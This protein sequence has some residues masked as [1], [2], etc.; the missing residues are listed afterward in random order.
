MVG[1]HMACS[2]LSYAAFLVAFVA[3]GCFLLQE[4]QVKRRTLGWWFHRLPSLM[5]LDRLNA[6]AITAGFVLL[7]AGLACGLAG[8]RALRG[9]WWVQDPKVYTALGLWA[10]YF[11]LWR[12]RRRQTL[13]GRRVAILSILGFGLLVFTLLQASYLS[14]SSHPYL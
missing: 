3:G 5:V 6:G 4:R 1:L 13:R 14:H 9:S 8:L 2:L 7:T 10:A 11:V 12:L